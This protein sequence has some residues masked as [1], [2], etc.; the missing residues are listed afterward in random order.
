ML[1][2][3]LVNVAAVTAAKGT[4]FAGI[5]LV[6]PNFNFEPTIATGGATSANPG[7]RF[8]HTFE[9]IRADLFYARR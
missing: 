3:I 1:R 6:S 4:R 9:I 2:A 7:E 8:A 5:N